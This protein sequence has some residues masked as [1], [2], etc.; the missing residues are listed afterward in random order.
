M[1]ALTEPGPRF[2]QGWFASNTFDAGDFDLDG[3]VAAKTSSGLSVSV[4]LPARNEAETIGAILEAINTVSGSLVDEIVVMDAGSDDGTADIA[5]RAGARVH[6]DHRVMPEFGPA[7]GKG[8]A[9]WRSLAVTSGDLVA[10]V[11]A[12]IR[13]PDPRFVSGLLAPLLARPEIQFVKAFYER[14]LEVGAVLHPSGGGRV[15]ELL[16]R[17]LLNLLWP[18]LSGLIQPLSG[19]YAGRRTLLEA[20]PFFTGYGVELGLLVDTLATVGLSG[21]AQVDLTERIH[22]NQNI[23]ALSRMAFGILEVGLARL[24]QQQRLGLE[25][26]PEHYTQFQREDG[27]V[28]PIAHHLPMVERPPHR[29]AM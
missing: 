10:F 25:A 18:D 14:P 17:P 28:V 4:V 7:L 24:N 29:P 8:D 19:E 16:A 15:T 5:A 26:L 1:T 23:D 2:P 27:Q 6:M 13:N 9:L 12:D 11:D 20:V 21:L 3:L 22:R